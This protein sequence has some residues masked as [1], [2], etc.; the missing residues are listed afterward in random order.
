MESTIVRAVNQIITVACH[1]KREK[2]IKDDSKIYGIVITYKDYFISDEKCFWDNIIGDQ[3][4][5]ELCNLDSKNFIFPENLFFIS[6]EDF[7]FLIAGAQVKN[8]SISDVLLEVADRN[9][10]AET[11]PLMLRQHLLEMWGEFYRPK[12][13]DDRLNECFSDLEKRSI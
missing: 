11:K 13:L 5:K 1:L 8:L 12:Y 7:D 4:S 3:V 10:T 9:R 6:I 2:Y